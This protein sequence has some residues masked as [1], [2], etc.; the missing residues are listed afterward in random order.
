MPATECITH[1]QA[2]SWEHNND[3]K[4]QPPALFH[5]TEPTDRAVCAANSESFISL[6][7][8]HNSV[9]QCLQRKV[10]TANITLFQPPL[11][12]LQHTAE[13]ASHG[14]YQDSESEA[15]HPLWLGALCTPGEIWGEGVLW[16]QC[17]CR[18]GPFFLPHTSPAELAKTRAEVQVEVS[19]QKM[20]LLVVCPGNSAW[21]EGRN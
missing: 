14:V 10:L 12:S 17:P 4:H 1:Q 21:E 15:E 3:I 8:F 2:A 19:R 5:W 9:I 11:A 16:N 6:S 7:C 20:S 13:T 18:A